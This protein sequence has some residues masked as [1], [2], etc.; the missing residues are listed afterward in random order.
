MKHIPLVPRP[1]LA[2][3][4]QLP[5][6][7]LCGAQER[8]VMTRDALCSDC[9]EAVLTQPTKTA[10]D[11]KMKDLADQGSSHAQITPQEAL[12]EARKASERGGFLTQDDYQMITAKLD[13]P[14]K[15]FF[16]LGLVGAQIRV[17]TGAVNVV[18]RAEPMNGGRGDLPEGT[19]PFGGSMSMP[20]PESTIPGW[21]EHGSNYFEHNKPMRS[22]GA[23]E[24]GFEEEA[25]MGNNLNDL[26]VASVTD[27]KIA[28]SEGKFSVS[29][30]EM[31]TLLNEG[32]GL[33]MSQSLRYQTY[34]DSLRF[35]AGR[36]SLADEFI[37]HSGDERRHA[38]ILTRRIVALNGV[39]DYKVE[40]PAVF[41][42]MNDELITQVLSE[43]WRW[44]QVGIEYYIRLR[45]ACGDSIFRY[46]VEEILT[47]EL[48]HSD[49]I[50]RL[51][52]VDPDLG[53]SASG[54]VNGPPSLFPSQGK[55]WDQSYSNSNAFEGLDKMG[56]CEDCGSPQTESNLEFCPVCTGHKA[57]QATPSCF[58]CK[59]AGLVAYC[60]CGSVA[61]IES[62][63]RP[64]KVWASWRLKADSVKKVRQFAEI[65]VHIEYAAGDTKTYDNGTSRKYH[66]DY[67]FIP[68]TTGADNEPLDVYL[69][70]NPTRKAYVINQLRPDGSFDEEK[71]MLGFS[72]PKIA[73][74]VYRSHYP[75]N[76]I[77]HF[78]GMRVM[79][80]DDFISEYVYPD[81]DDAYKPKLQKRIPLEQ[82][83]PGVQVTGGHE[84]GDSDGC[85]EGDSKPTKPPA[86]KRDLSHVD[87]SSV[88]S[89]SE[90][91]AKKNPGMVQNFWDGAL[92]LLG[93]PQF[94]APSIKEGS[95]VA[96]MPTGVHPET[97]YDMPEQSPISTDSDSGHP[98]EELVCVNAG[99][100]IGFED[101]Q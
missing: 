79:D 91:A 24:G 98:F 82:T 64:I 18:D 55:M 7:A 21:Q 17:K 87:T 97:Q 20:Q 95:V 52:H 32:L 28:G 25:D 69:G 99:I 92:G 77:G 2:E 29:L 75:K 39:P 86:P 74:A 49:D 19:A 78:G 88:L 33:E 9:V 5:Y 89:P 42:P 90:E 37:G 15:Y 27:P 54:V 58:N 38:A 70:N 14:G 84:P 56:D 59:G 57:A 8:E 22:E 48:E 63:Y 66:C 46:T 76:G 83:G 12:R 6:K 44:E 50:A 73:E 45:D 85:G 16:R 65:P 43:L 1:L 3:I 61:L 100:E 68:G 41:D 10:F 13:E 72:S 35:S 31:L 47:Q 23:K 71:V 11:F 26:T 96:E 36:D 40:R 4:S 60:K 53:K 51:G 94:K 81:K 93:G 101:F 30:P 67:G 62:G 34:A 80:L